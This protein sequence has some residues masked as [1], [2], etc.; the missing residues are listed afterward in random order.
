MGQ[1][2]EDV[3]G[4]LGE[5]HAWFTSNLQGRTMSFYDPLSEQPE[6][7]PELSFSLHLGDSEPS[8][9]AA[10]CD[11]ASFNAD[12]L[13]LPDRPVFKCN[14]Q[15]RR[16]RYGDIHDEELM[17]YFSRSISYP[18]FYEVLITLSVSPMSLIVRVNGLSQSWK[19]WLSS[20]RTSRLTCLIIRSIT[21]SSM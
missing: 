20:G 19:I 10:L 16:T 18:I 1:K 9:T 11:N 21:P 15:L 17:Q 7:S 2:V 6:R 5:I 13:R 12:W 4:M 3:H 8:D 14:C